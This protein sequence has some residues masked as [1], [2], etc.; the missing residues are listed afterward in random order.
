M[1]EFNTQPPEQGR[2]RYGVKD[3]RRGMRAIDKWRFTSPDKTAIEQLAETYGG[4][5]QPW[6]E[7][8]AAVKNQWELLST[9][10]TVK[11]Y[12]S[13]GSLTITRERWGGRGIERRCTVDGSSC[14]L[15]S[16]TGAAHHQPCACA[17]E[18]AQWGD[19]THCKF[20][21]RLNVI[22]PA[23]R[24]GGVWRM[25]AKGQ[26]F[27]HEAPGMIRLIETLSDQQITPVDLTLEHRSALVNGERVNFIVPKFT[28]NA[29]PHQMI[30]GESLV[31]IGSN[32]PAPLELESPDD[33]VID[34]E[35]VEEGEAWDIPPPNVRVRRNP[36]LSGPKY[37]RDE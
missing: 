27:A 6:N 4:E 17:E 31:Q 34:A 24:F 21:S 37:V 36:D 32:H 18:G 9:S 25:E 26:T 11:C 2:L 10:N 7:P 19:K 3:P 14:S 30:A 16:R 15:Y 13:P 35:I 28:M 22:L 1:E 33:Q 23:C 12:I 8:K 20:Y 29:T 5:P